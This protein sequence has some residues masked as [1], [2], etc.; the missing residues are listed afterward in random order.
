MQTGSAT[1]TLP[2]CLHPSAEGKQEGREGLRVDGWSL[3][4]QHS[5]THTHT[6]TQKKK[7]KKNNKYFE[8]KNSWGCRPNSNYLLTQSQVRYMTNCSN[9]PIQKALACTYFTHAWADRHEQT[10]QLF[11]SFLCSFGAALNNPA[12]HT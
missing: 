11:L 2:C 1:C 12:T 7:K 6:H 9:L 3:T 10:V 8:L 5:H 4:K